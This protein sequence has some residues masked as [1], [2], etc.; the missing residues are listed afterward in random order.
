MADGPFYEKGVYRGRITEQAL[1][2]SSNG[3]AQIVIRFEV[4]A[5]VERDN[6]MSQVEERQRTAFL[7]ITEKTIDRI[8]QQLQALGYDRESFRFLDPRQPGYFD[9]T[10]TEADFVCNHEEYQGK[11]REK[12]QVRTPYESGPLEVKPIE[13]KKLR[14]IDNLFGKHLK[15]AAKQGSGAPKPTAQQSAA[16][17]VITDDDVPF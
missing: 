15:A 12:W 6:S 2:E 16:P 7:T 1:G 4:T 11:N 14:E 8:A 13:S 10:N 3:N 9:L 5:K 17:A